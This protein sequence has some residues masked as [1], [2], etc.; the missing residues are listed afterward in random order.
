[1]EAT[2][3]ERLLAFVRK[4]GSPVVIIFGLLDTFYDDQAPLFE[5]K[6]SL[7]RVIE[8]LQRLKQEHVSVLLASMDMQPAS[9]G[10]NAL[11]PHLLTAM[12]KIYRVENREGTV[13][14]EDELPKRG[15]KIRNAK[16]DSQFRN[17][18]SLPARWKPKA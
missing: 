15:G 10:R 11:L 5:V 18:Q 9:P 8:A 2:I 16:H 6:A 4:R 13:R 12:D 3:T 14:I 7:Q 17:Q 1:M